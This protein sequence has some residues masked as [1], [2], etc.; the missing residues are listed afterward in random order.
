MG[1]NCWLLLVLAAIATGGCSVPTR[2]ASRSA[3][4]VCQGRAAAH[5]ITPTPRFS[6]PTAMA[7]LNEEERVPVA[8]VRAGTPPRSWARRTEFELVRATAEV[9][10]PRTVA[11]DDAMRGRPAP[12]LVIVGAG[13]DGR[14]WRMRELRDIDV[15]EVDHPAS[16]LDKRERIGDLPL[17]SRTLTYAP[18]DLAHDRLADA[19]GAAGH[20]PTVATT[21]VW[22]GVVPYLSKSEVTATVTAIAGLSAPGSCLIVNYQTPS[23]TAGLGRQAVRTATSLARRPS[24]WT[25]EPRRSSWTPAAMRSLLATIGFPP[26]ADDDLLTIAGRLRL[27]VRQR[28]SLSNGRVAIAGN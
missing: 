1:A 9:I 23:F 22:E 2:G 7:F 28:R 3:V 6:D 17:M 14:A 11:I 21:W 10:V 24:V 13:L 20:L 12:Q 18:A 16:Q 19:L 15:F 26:E 27:P 4:L 8:Q 25:D 5:G